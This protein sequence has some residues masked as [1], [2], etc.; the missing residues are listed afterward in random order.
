MQKFILLLFIIFNLNS[1]AQTRE[2]AAFYDFELICISQKDFPIVTKPENKKDTPSLEKSLLE[3]IRQNEQ[4]VTEALKQ[5]TNKLT[6]K[7]Y[8]ALEG[9][10]QAQFT[11]QFLRLKKQQ[12]NC[13]AYIQDRILRI[14]I[15]AT[16]VERKI[17]LL[18]APTEFEK[19]TNF[20]K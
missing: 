19:L 10:L 20:N 8:M 16:K 9:R 14:P 12:T 2:N 3:W 15:D 13:I 5:K 6:R 4:Q 11:H 17:I 18:V 1:N 7:D